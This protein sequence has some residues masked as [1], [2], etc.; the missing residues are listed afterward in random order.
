[1]AK[2]KKTGGKNFEP[3]ESGNPNGRP[4]LTLEQREFRNA[5]T[6]E[7]I[8]EFKFLWSLKEDELKQITEDP[9]TPAIRKAIAHNIFSAASGK[10]GGGYSLQFILD[11]TIGRVKEEIDHNL[12]GNIHVQLVDIINKLEGKEDNDGKSEKGY[13]ED[14]ET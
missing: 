7:I 11:R 9:N 3:G 2:G 10:W 6:K 1:M 5:K 12:K 14:S 13:E 4:P 8:E